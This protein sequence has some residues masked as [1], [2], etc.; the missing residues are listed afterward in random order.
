MTIHNPDSIAAPVGAYV[1]G[2]ETAPG[3]RILHVSGQIGMA[4]DGTIPAGTKA[5]SE[6]VW[7]NIA[8]ILASAG[9][10]ISDIVKMTAYLLG[11]EDLADYIVEKH[12]SYVEKRLQEIKTYLK[13]TATVHGEHNPELIKIRDLFEVSAGELAK[14]MKKE[15]SQMLKS[16]NSG[17]NVSSSEHYTSLGKSLQKTKARNKAQMKASGSNLISQ[18]HA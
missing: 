17:I 6:L 2:L 18:S 1:H 4:K 15:E 8:E 7:Q 16:D 5:Q 3:A 11:P 12:H 14:H 10:E 9:M 13:K